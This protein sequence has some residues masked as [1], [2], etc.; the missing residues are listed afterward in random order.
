MSAILKTEDKSMKTA[1][2]RINN[3]IGQLEGIKKMLLST[4]DDCLAILTQMK[5]VKSAMS[6]LTEQMLSTE[7]DRCLKK[8][9]AQDKKE[10]MEVILKELIKHNNK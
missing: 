6:S 7:L 1:E 2:Q 5:A 3:I 9:F 4:P 10:K 8:G